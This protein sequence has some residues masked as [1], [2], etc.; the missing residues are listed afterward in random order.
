MIWDHSLVTGFPGSG[1][2]EAVHSLPE[3]RPRF[4]AKV[5]V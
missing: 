1:I 3:D 4:E 5:D 2:M